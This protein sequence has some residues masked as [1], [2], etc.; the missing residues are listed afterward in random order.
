MA[1]VRKFNVPGASSDIGFSLRTLCNNLRLGRT[2]MNVDSRGSRSGASDDPTGG[3]DSSSNSSDD[4]SSG[5][6]G[7]GGDGSGGST[8]PGY[9]PDDSSKSSD[10][11]SSTNSG[12]NSNSSRY[13]RNLKTRSWKRKNVIGRRHDSTLV[14]EQDGDSHLHGHGDVA[15]VADATAA[16]GSGIHL[17]NSTKQGVSSSSLTLVAAVAGKREYYNMEHAGAGTRGFTLQYPE[18]QSMSTTTRY[19]QAATTTTSGQGS[20]KLPGTTFWSGTSGTTDPYL[21]LFQVS[22][23]KVQAAP[24]ASFSHESACCFPL[25][26]TATLWHLENGAPIS[27]DIQC[28]SL[29]HYHDRLCNPFSS[30]RDSRRRSQ[31]RH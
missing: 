20:D 16:V 3:R 11:S 23:G 28:V 8:S 31:Q 26:S 14:V 27:S 21:D 4:S 17:K 7:G 2:T 15:L 25:D 1:L 10:D 29:P 6:G 13:S 22:N 30:G 18:D 5:G 9:R 12:G 19:F 24:C